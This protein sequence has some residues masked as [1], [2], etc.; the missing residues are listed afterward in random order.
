MNKRSKKPVPVSPAVIW[1]LLQRR[2]IV[3]LKVGNIDYDYAID[4]CRAVYANGT[5]RWQRTIMLSNLSRNSVIS[6]FATPYHN[7]AYKQAE[8][9][10]R[11]TTQTAFLKR[12]GKHKL[13]RAL[14]GM[15]AHDARNELAVVAVYNKQYKLIAGAECEG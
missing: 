2:D 9:F 11:D 10:V 6:C 4:R 13:W 12:P 7:K 8:A 1:E 15:A 3:Y 14:L 5:V